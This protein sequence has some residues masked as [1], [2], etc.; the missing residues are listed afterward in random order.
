M[1]VVAE[2]VETAAQADTLRALGCPKLQGYLFSRP[3]SAE[4]LTD[5][6]ARGLVVNV[7]AADTIRLLPPLVV[8]SAQI[9]RAIGLF[10]ESL[11][12]LSAK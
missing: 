11:V 9:E 6:L 4:A 3:I 8:E 5:L 10:G 12:G 7:P 1:Q 2:G